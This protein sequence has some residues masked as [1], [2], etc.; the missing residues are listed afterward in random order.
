MTT[1]QSPIQLVL[2]LH[3][4]ESTHL[5]SVCVC[6]W[7]SVFVC[8]CL[9][10]WDGPPLVQQPG[11]QLSDCWLR[12]PKGPSLHKQKNKARKCSISWCTKTC[13]RPWG[14]AT[15]GSLLY[16]AVL[17]SIDFILWVAAIKYGM[18]V[19]SLRTWDWPCGCLVVQIPLHPGLCQSVLGQDALPTLPWNECEWML[20]V[21]GGAVWPRLAANQ[22][23][24]GQPWLQVAPHPQCAW[25]TGPTWSVLRA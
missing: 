25:K 10:V 20:A 5:S 2:I 16:F 7:L 23:P 14:A 11:A 8:V 13:I 21:V 6:V 15:V 3:K 4:E 24:P 9:H 1:N 12:H 18:L 17:I 22:S 19:C